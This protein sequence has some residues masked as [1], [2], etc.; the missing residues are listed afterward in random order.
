M[1]LTVGQR[2]EAQGA[3]FVGREPERAFLAQRAR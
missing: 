3:G 2:I 1:T